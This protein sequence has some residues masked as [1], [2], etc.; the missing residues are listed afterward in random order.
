MITVLHTLYSAMW[1]NFWTPSAPTIGAVA[2]HFFVSQHRH[3]QRHQELMD[4]VG[5][6]K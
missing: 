3:Q 4:K 6:S 2:A 5:E 1:A